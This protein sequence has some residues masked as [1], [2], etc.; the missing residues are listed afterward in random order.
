MTK[1][2]MI[3]KLYTVSLLLREVEA[4][5]VDEKDIDPQYKADVGRAIDITVDVASHLLDV[6]TSKKGGER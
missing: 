2:D 3:M 5:L 4:A 6:E 1:H